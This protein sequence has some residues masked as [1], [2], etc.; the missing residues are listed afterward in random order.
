M[1][2]NIRPHF[3]P[4]QPTVK[5]TDKV[6]Y[7]EYLPDLRLQHFIHCY[8]QLKTNSPLTE[9]FHYRVVAD[10]CIDLFFEIQSPQESFVMGFANAYTTFPLPHSFH[11]IGIRFL[12]AAFPQLFNIAASELT[13]RFEALSLVVPATSKFIADQF[14]SPLTTQEIIHSLDQHFLQILS[15]THLNPDHR[16]YNAMHIILEQRGMVNIERDLNTG[17]SP[18]QLRRLFEFYIGDTAKT[19]SKIVRFQH[20]LHT[21]PSTLYL[22]KHKLF[23]E[24]GYYDQAHFIKEFKTLFG[25]TPAK[26]FEE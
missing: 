11:Y 6:S 8:W 7:E 18:R 20:L 2:P 1:I 10:G 26:A 19:F 5:N 17:I 14:Q 3:H 15:Q 24:S 22:R 25:L 12:P 16:F 9:T 23:F 21:N 4:V 13:N